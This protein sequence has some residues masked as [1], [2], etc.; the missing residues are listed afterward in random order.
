RSR[1][2]ISTETARA[3]SLE[4]DPAIEAVGVFAGEEA[5]LMLYYAEM[6]IIQ[7]IQLHAGP[8]DHRLVSEDLITY[9]K[10]RTPVPVIKAI[11]F[12]N[13]SDGACGLMDTAADYLLLDHGRGGSGQVFDW[14]LIAERPA[15]P[16]FLAGGIGPDNAR[17]AEARFHPY[18][19]DC[20]S[21]LETEG[22]KDFEKMKQMLEVI[23]NK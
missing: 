17:A 19:L 3:L 14:N 15:K 9:L 1:R 4:L 13:K 12:S 7:A 16:F 21:S 6:D 8:G 10:E 11:S 22:Y 5:D 18:C 23:R 2:Q 20:S